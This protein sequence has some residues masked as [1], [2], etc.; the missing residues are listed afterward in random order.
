[1]VN[2]YHDSMPQSP[3]AI[4]WPNAQAHAELDDATLDWA[5]AEGYMLCRAP[6]NLRR[7]RVPGGRLHPKC[8]R[9]PDEGFAHEQVLEMIESLASR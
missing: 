3:D 9:H 8:V 6:R 7:L 2:L 5:I 1:M 4:V